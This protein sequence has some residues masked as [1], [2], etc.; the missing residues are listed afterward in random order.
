MGWVMGSNKS[1]CAPPVARSFRFLCFW[2]YHQ[3]IPLH[4]HC[5]L[6]FDRFIYQPFIYERRGPR[7]SENFRGNK[8]EKA[9]LNNINDERWR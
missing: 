8:A 7:S 5:T 6:T 1:G 4:L 2:F 3:E 9:T